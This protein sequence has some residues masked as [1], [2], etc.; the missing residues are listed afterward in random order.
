MSSDPDA[1]L[2]RWAW[3]VPGIERLEL[4]VEPWNEASWRTA[5]AAGFRREGVLRQWQAVGQARRDV[6]IYS[7]LPYDAWPSPPE[8][9]RRLSAS[10]TD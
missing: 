6:F 1:V 3:T 8:R 7:L 5:E 2:V 10:A 4:Y 9:T